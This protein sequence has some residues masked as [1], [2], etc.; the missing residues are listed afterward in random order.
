[1]RIQYI[2]HSCF[3]LVTEEGERVVIDPYDESI[4]LTPVR[5]TADVVLITHHHSDHD[6][7]DGVSGDYTVI[8]AP[9]EY[10]TRG[11]RIR[12]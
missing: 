1:M 3:Y 4:G 8:D 6:C 10:E 9:G 12:G 2:G 7:L 11:L 5:L